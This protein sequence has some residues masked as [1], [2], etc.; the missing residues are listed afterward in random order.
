M[1]WADTILACLKRADVR[2]LVYVPDEVLIP[3]TEGAERDGGFRVLVATREEEA[4]GILAGAALGGLRGAL[5]MQSSGFGNSVN[6]LASLIVPYQ[7]PVPMLISQRGVLGEYNAVQVPIGRVL[8]PALA[9]LGI[10][11]RTLERADELEAVVG[12]SLE[13]CYRTQAPVALI[14]STLLTGGKTD[15]G[16]AGGDRG[17][18]R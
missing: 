17:E 14:L 5:L 6:A 9:A 4:F 10:V 2:L 7:L 8:G 1:Q 3:L 12:R 11:H 16:P 13:Q 18:A 15:P